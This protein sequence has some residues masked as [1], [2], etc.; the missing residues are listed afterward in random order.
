MRIVMRYMSQFMISEMK[1]ER[2]LI[3]KGKFIAKVNADQ[4]REIDPVK[5]CHTS[6]KLYKGMAERGYWS[7]LLM[8]AHKSYKEGDYTRAYLLYSFLAEL[9]YEVC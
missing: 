9:G 5:P 2:G 4:A 8:I 3:L 1:N 7:H 6:V